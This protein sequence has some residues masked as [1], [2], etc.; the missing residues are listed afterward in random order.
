VKTSGIY[1]LILTMMS[2]LED[3]NDLAKVAVIQAAKEVVH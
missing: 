3:V 1:R 2:G